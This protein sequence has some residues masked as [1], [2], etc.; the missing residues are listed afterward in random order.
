MFIVIDISCAVV[1]HVKVKK[2]GA[3]GIYED[4]AIKDRSRGIGTLRCPEKHGIL[5]FVNIDFSRTRMYIFEPRCKWY[6][7]TYFLTCLVT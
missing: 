2:N 4:C 3:D 7:D 1:V 6:P 5:V